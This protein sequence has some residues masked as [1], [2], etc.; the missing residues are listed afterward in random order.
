MSEADEC[1][2][3]AV[4]AMRLAT[5]MDDATS[6]FLRDAENEQP[7]LLEYVMRRGAQ[8]ICEEAKADLERLKEMADQLRHSKVLSDRLRSASGLSTLRLLE[9]EVEDD[10]PMGDC[11]STMLQIRICKL[12][13]TGF[14]TSHFAVYLRKVD[15]VASLSPRKTVRQMLTNS[16]L[17]KLWVEAF[18]EVSQDV[19]GV[20]ANE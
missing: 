7:A 16:L 9:D 19:V 4:R 12:Q 10:K 3:L 15:A 20:K 18:A 8:A 5:T 11:T 14:G 1:A 2:N 6:I 17:E 13:R